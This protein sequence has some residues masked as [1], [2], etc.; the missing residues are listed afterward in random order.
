MPSGSSA[1]PGEQHAG[2][3]ERLAGR[4]AHQRLGQVGVD[5]EPLRPPRRLGAVPGDVGVA[6]AVVDAAAGEH[7]HAGDEL[8]RRVPAH[9][10]HLDVPAVPRRVSRTSITVA[11]GLGSQRIWSVVMRASC[12]PRGVRVRRAK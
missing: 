4:G 10:E 11:A 5:A 2:L 8:H 3:L 7:H 1:G 6:V 12:A 9:Q